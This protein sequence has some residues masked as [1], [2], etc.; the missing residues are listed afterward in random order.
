MTT[1][2]LSLPLL[3]KFRLSAASGKPFYLFLP[4]CSPRTCF[5]YLG[6]HLFLYSSS[7]LS[8][9]FTYQIA[10]FKSIFRIILLLMSFTL[11]WSLEWLCFSFKMISANLLAHFNLLYPLLEMQFLLAQTLSANFSACSHGSWIY[12]KQKKSASKAKC[13]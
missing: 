12:W 7:H 4:F 8:V 6:I 10:I 2:I 13:H 5:C 3:V 11:R 9:L 1:A